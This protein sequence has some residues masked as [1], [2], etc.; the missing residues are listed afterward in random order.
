VVP[1]SIPT[2]GP[3]LLML[4]HNKIPTFSVQYQQKINMFGQQIICL[5]KSEG[6]RTTPS[7]VAFTDTERLIGDTAKNQVTMN[8]SNTIFG[9]LFCNS[10][11][12]KLYIC[13][14]VCQ[15]PSYQV[16]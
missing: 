3:P 1:R 5:H 14:D 6:N 10:V 12:L 7:Y 2:A 15:V 16:Q 4:F 13:I 8:P 9:K 11:K